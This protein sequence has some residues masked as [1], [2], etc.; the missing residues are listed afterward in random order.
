MTHGNHLRDRRLERNG[1]RTRA[2]SAGASEEFARRFA[3]HRSK[4]THEVWLV[5]EAR[6][7]GD[8]APRVRRALQPPL[9]RRVQ[10]ADARESFESD[11]QMLGTPRAQRPVTDA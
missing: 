11:A 9:E 1:T 5:R 3:E 6:C 8:R 2:P 10:P 7:R 4:I